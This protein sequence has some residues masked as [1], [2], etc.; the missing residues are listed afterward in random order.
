MKICTKCKREL[1]ES[2]FTYDKQKLGLRPSCIGCASFDRLKIKQKEK[3]DNRRYYVEN[4]DRLKTE[5]LK[6]YIT[7]SNSPEFKIQMRNRNL[8]SKFGITLDQYNEIFLKQQGKCA[9]CETD[10]PKGRGSLHVDHDHKTGKIRGLLCHNCNVGL[11]NFKES[12]D[13]FKKAAIYLCL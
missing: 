1:S 7:R 8:I 10:K 5:A 13:I 6:R 2:D 12:I 11:G 3:E 9:I 4:R